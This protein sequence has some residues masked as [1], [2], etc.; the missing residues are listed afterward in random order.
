M[1]E[2]REFNNI[3]RFLGKF[4]FLPH[5]RITYPIPTIK[6]RSLF[7]GDFAKTLF[8]MVNEGRKNGLSDMKIAN[9]LG[10]PTKLFKIFLI[11]SMGA[12]FT[13]LTKSERVQLFTDL[14]NCLKLRKARGDYLSRDRVNLILRKSDVGSIIQ[15]KNWTSVDSP[16]LPCKFAKFNV[17]LRCLADFVYF[18]N[19]VTGE[20]IHG[21]YDVSNYFLGSHR[22]YLL[23]RSFM[24][25]RP[26]DL[27]GFLE[28]LPFGTINSY[29]VYKDLDIEINPIGALVTKGS[30][31][32]CL[33]Q[34]SV[35]HI[36]H[37]SDVEFIDV[38]DLPGYTELLAKYVIIGSRKVQKLSLI[39]KAKKYADI[40]YYSLKKLAERVDMDW[41][42]TKEA[43]ENIEELRF[44]RVFYEFR[45]KFDESNNEEIKL[46]LAIKMHDPRDTTFASTDLITAEPN[47]M[48][49]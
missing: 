31:K 45:N 33:M 10:F 37:N 12:K 36:R 3:V 46:G 18:D 30:L 35:E 14:V 26:V 47:W 22:C 4:Q 29:A 8:E 24:E 40:T 32:E 42:P 23:V 49:E 34:F 16:E 11:A 19:H 48:Y 41:R 9:A 44:P 5:A 1:L 15:G 20:E 13:D 38:D 28:N 2:P 17:A 25:V 39:D 7:A 6:A 43:Y 27:W 21:P